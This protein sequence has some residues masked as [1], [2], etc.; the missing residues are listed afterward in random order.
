[1]DQQTMVK[2]QTKTIEKFCLFKQVVPKVQHLKLMSV[3]FYFLL[4]LIQAHKYD[5]VTTLNLLFQISDNNIN[6]RTTNGQHMGIKGSV[7]VN[8][9]VGPCSFTHKFVVCEGLTRPFILGEEFLSHHC[10]TLGWTNNNKRFAE[11]RNKVIAVT[12]QAVMDDRIMVSH[13][14]KIPVRNFA[15]VPTKCPNNV[16]I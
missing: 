1:M 11:Y 13:S 7:L 12:S 3:E 9:K 5:T 4:F 6:V 2:V 16:F 10:F 14:V 8:F 15:M